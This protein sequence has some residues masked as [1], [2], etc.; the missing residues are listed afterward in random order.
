[1]DSPRDSDPRTIYRVNFLDDRMAKH[2]L[3]GLK[4]KTRVSVWLLYSPFE[5]TA[6][7]LK[8]DENFARSLGAIEDF[9]QVPFRI[10]DPSSALNAARALLSYKYSMSI[11]PMREHIQTTPGLFFLKKKPIVYHF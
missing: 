2:W 5:G 7:G 1:M 11:L 4:Y 10:L 3:L 9:S 6:P 8:I